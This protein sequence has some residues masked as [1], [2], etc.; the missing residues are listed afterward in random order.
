MGKNENKAS[1]AWEVQVFELTMDNPEDQEELNRQLR[2]AG[3]PDRCT[4]ATV[5][6]PAQGESTTQSPKNG[7]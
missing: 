4:L 6:E 5:G 2:K 7:L 3:D 1:G